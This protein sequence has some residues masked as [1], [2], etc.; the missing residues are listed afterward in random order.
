MKLQE[1]IK[2]IKIK[3]ILNE[4]DIDITGI[5]YNSKTVKQGEI[6]VCLKG[7]HSD[8]HEFFFFLYF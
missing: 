8:G 3:K 7:E 1:L 4:K 5:S 6:F 2:N